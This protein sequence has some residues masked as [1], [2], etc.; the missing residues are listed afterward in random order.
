[1]EVVIRGG[2]VVIPSQRLK[3]ELLAVVS[4]TV[5]GL[6]LAIGLGIFAL[7]PLGDRAIALGISA[8]IVAASVTPIVMVLLGT[9]SAV[10][11]AP[12]SVSAYLINGVLASLVASS[13]AVG[14]AAEL[15]VIV[16]VVSLVLV[17]ASIMQG[18]L[19]R[20]G[21]AEYVKYVPYPVLSGFQN[22]AAALLLLSQFPALAGVSRPFAWTRL[23]TDLAE[24]LPLSL[25][26]GLATFACALWG[27]R[28]LPKLPPVLL[29]LAVGTVLYY[30]C[31][32]AGLGPH[33]GPRLGAFHVPHLREHGAQVVA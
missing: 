23:G 33:L 26:I 21:L 11:Y 18:L 28:W 12:R 19:A 17:L 7:E 8:G 32:A 29:G 24:A 22:A 30:L 31:V 13:F 14:H 1:M 25:A 4:T 2:G 10:I 27:K 6:P 20:A 15:P 9:D 5:L 16:A 3:R